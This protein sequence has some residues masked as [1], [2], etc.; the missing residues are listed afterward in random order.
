MVRGGLSL[1][2]AILEMKSITKAFPG[3]IALDSVNFSVFPG[4]IHALVGKNGAG[5]STLISIISGVYG[6]DKGELFVDGSKVSYSHQLLIM[7][8]PVM[9]L[10][11][12]YL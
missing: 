10:S 5:K 12:I 6:P 9:N 7:F 2:E 8:L 11:I 3:V 1:K 4:E